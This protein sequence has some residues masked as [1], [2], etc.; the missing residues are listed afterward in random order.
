[1]GQLRDMMFDIANERL[2]IDKR[3][4]QLTHTAL[5]L[6]QEKHRRGKGKPK[7]VARC[8]TCG[9]TVI[10][11]C[12]LCQPEFY[13]DIKIPA[14]KGKETKVFY[15]FTDFVQARLKDGWTAGKDLD[16]KANRYIK[17]LGLKP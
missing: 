14:I 15:S 4:S 10:M 1:M 13:S 16:D 5:D 2:P 17:Q 3:V 7:N 11:P 8:K 9:A 6:R 12:V